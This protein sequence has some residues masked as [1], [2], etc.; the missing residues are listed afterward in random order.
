MPMTI[1]RA[2][3]P[4]VKHATSPGS[5]M[6]SHHPEERTTPGA[7]EDGTQG[8]YYLHPYTKYYTPLHIIGPV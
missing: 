7:A 1:A 8:V 2:A 6:V 3:P 5:V 4:I